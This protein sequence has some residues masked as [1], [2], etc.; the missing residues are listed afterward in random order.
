MA[1][2]SQRRNIVATILVPLFYLPEQDERAQ[3]VYALVSGNA[4]QRL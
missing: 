4:G 1:Q 3:T 2:A